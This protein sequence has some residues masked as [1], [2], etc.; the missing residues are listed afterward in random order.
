MSARGLRRAS[1]KAIHSGIAVVASPI[2]WMVSASSATEPEA[3]DDQLQRR[4]NGQDD[5][6]PFDRPDA[7]VRRR[8]GRIDYPV[9]MRP[10]GM[11]VM[12]MTMC[13]VIARPEPNQLRTRAPSTGI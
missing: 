7:S 9:A 11:I 6:W 2:L 13:G 10:A 12:A 4:G 3:H 5:E 8:N 1:R